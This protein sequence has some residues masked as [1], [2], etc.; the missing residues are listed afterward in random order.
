[1]VSILSNNEICS[2]VS[3]HK[4]YFDNVLVMKNGSGENKYVGAA[5]IGS[6]IKFYML[7]ICVS[8]FFSRKE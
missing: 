7:K 2:F 6:L 3:L 1:M 4:D 5:E 8:F